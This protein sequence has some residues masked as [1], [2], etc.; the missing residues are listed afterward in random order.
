MIHADLFEAFKVQVKNEM[1]QSA[2]ARINAV[3]LG[4]DNYE[5]MIFRSQEETKKWLGL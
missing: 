5:V 1:E 3:L 4:E 2:C